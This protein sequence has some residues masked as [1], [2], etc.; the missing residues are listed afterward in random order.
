MSS[1][2]GMYGTIRAINITTKPRLPL[3][4]SRLDKVLLR[5]MIFSAASRKKKRS[6]IKLKATP[7]VS[8]TTERTIP[9]KM[10]NIKVLAVEKIIAGGKPK[11]LTKSVSRKL[12]IIAPEPKLAI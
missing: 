1:T 2:E 9:Q 10:P 7:M 11:A 4:L 3:Y 5:L 8:A 12:K 6:R